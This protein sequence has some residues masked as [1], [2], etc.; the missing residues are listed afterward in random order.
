MNWRAE[1]RAR[2][3]V[4]SHW[5]T[6]RAKCT[7]S[8]G[9]SVH[10]LAPGQRTALEAPWYRNL[11]NWILAHVGLGHR[12]RPALVRSDD[13]TTVWVEFLSGERIVIA[14]IVLPGEGRNGARG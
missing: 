10:S 6:W 12:V 2:A 7:T 13:G 1:D 9:S 11:W 5:T 14:N 4:Y 3:F 8:S